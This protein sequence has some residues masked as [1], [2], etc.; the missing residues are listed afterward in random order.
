MEND[1]VRVGIRLRDNTKDDIKGFRIE[2]ND[3]LVDL[4]NKIYGFDFC[5]DERTNNQLIFESILNDML[6]KFM[7]G[8]SCAFFVYG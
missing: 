6:R 7:K 5:Y 2:R 3:T 4:E 1:N 8:I